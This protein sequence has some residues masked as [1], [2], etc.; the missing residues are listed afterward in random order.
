MRK[1][2]LIAAISNETGI[3]K[4]DV[5][6]A[7]ESFFSEVK[8]AVTRGETVSLR[9]FG[10][11]TVK[12]RAGKK[13]RHIHKNEDIFVPEHYIP[14]FVPSREFLQAIQTIEIKEH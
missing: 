6:V 10:S 9:K 13:A 4:V 2:E 3:P 5:L 14:K 11:F 8:A 1:I 7:M 12:K